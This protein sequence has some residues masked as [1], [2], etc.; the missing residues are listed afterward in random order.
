MPKSYL[1]LVRERRAL[2]FCLREF[3]RSRRHLPPSLIRGRWM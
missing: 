1:Q 3:D 2:R